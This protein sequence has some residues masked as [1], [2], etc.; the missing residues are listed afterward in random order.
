MFLFPGTGQM[1]LIGDLP[2]DG[3]GGKRHRTGKSPSTRA[4]ATIGLAV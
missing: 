4:V 3:I 1:A 2:T